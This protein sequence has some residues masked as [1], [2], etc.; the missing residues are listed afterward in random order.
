[1]VHIKDFKGKQIHMTGIAGSSMSGLAEM[2]IKQGYNVRGSDGAESYM[3]DYLRKKGIPVVVGHFAENIE[4]ADLHVYTAAILPDNIERQTVAKLGIPSLERKELL[5]QLM[6]NY[7]HAACVCGTHGKTT[8]SGMLAQTLVDCGLDPT[9]HIGGMV[10]SI[11]GSTRVGSHELFV[12]EACEFNASFLT[13]SPTLAVIM[14]LEEDHLDY[15]RDINHIKET[16]AKFLS[17]LPADGIAIGFGDDPKVVELLNA[18]TQRTYTFGFNETNHYY[19]QNIEYNELACA[20]FDIIKQGKN[21]GR[22]SL[23]VPGKIQ[24]IDAIAAFA[25]ADVLGADPKLAMESLSN[26][27]GVHRRFELTGV[28]DGVEVYHDYGHNPQEMAQVLQTAHMRPHNRLWAVM[29]P[30][31]YSRVKRLFCDYI[32]C[33]QIADFTLITDICAAREKDPGDIHSI[34]LVDAMQDQGINAVYTPT[35]DDTENYLKAHWQPGDI[36]VT[37][38][39]GDINKLN[40]Q[41][42]EHSKQN[43]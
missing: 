38:G 5:G 41:I 30:H 18:L 40:I 21:L 24:I 3:V 4:G 20:S 6:E 13:M 33:T 9:V 1:M 11:G 36:V 14:N 43:A 34:M 23:G 26:F 25:A 39:C 31:T 8:T 17:L 10:D 7:T 32:T 37:L 27:Q 15:Y 22:L 29:Q 42:E 19:P 28:Y 16:F 35:F 2:L 12:A